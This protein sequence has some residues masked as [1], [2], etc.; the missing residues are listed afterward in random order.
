MFQRL[1]SLALAAAF[2]SGATASGMA[3][4]DILN[5]SQLIPGLGTWDISS[6]GLQA[7]SAAGIVIA[8][9]PGY[10]GSFNG[11]DKINVR[12]SSIVMPLITVEQR[13]STGPTFDLNR[14]VFKSGTTTLDRTAA[15]SDLTLNLATSSITAHVSGIDQLAHTTTD[16]GVLTLFSLSN[17][18][19]NPSGYSF[20]GQMTMTAAT[21]D[22]LFDIFGLPSVTPIKD[23][24]QGTSWGTFTTTAVPEPGSYAL[25]F[26]GLAG[27]LAVK[28]RSKA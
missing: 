19:G 7:F 20:S 17:L 28:R 4:A 23:L 9:P 15:I 13:V 21:T 6:D 22:A 5:P 25:M 1:K 10:T 8:T 16:Y 12:F 27:V 14:S 26:A 11:A 24:Y 3:Q 2:V 18:T